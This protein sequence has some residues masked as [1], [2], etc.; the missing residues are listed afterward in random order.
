MKKRVVVTGVGAVTPVGNTAEDFW[1]SLV[2]GKSGLGPI[3]QINTDNFPV[4]ISAEVKNFDPTVYMNPKE[5]RR[6]DIFVHFAVA[7]SKM[8]VS[9]AKIETGQFDPYRFGVLIG[10]G[11]GGLRV[12]EKQ[13]QVLLEKGPSRISP[14]MIP[15]LICNIAAGIVAIEAG[16]KGP[17]SCAVTACASGTHSIGDA[18]KIIQRGD[19]DLMIS[20]GSES[21]VTELGLSGFCSMKALST[22]N[23]DPLRASRPF[24][25]ERDG[26]V[27]GE[28]A[29]ILILEELE[30]AIKRGAQIYAEICGYGMSC[31][32]YHIT[33]PDPSA[34]AAARCLQNAIKDASMKP[35]DIDYINAHGTST[36]LN[37]AT[38]TRAIKIA[39]GEDAAR[40]V[41]ISSTK[42]MTGH[43]LG[44]AGG[45]EAIASVLAI[46]N[47]LIPP[48][49]N[50]E[51][52]DPDC[53]L[54]YTPN[55]ACKTTVNTALSNS[56]G[57]GG[58]NASLVFKKYVA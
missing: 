34:N 9:D 21:C 33:A 13:H 43:L 29:G 44:A 4:K 16:A 23:D 56:L 57:F 53:D 17:N 40:K 47:D 8:A 54:D 27:M 2:A 31:D 32:A 22:R 24:D 41:K 7:A 50:Y 37:D 12:T 6:T 25:K 36:P 30:H 19:A 5:A 15:M 51:N 39:F 42:S 49:I 46:K 38:E 3:T 14:F 11:I 18:F 35:E 55:E 20:G 10:S 26:F 58:H 1:K 28:G 52:P 48:T 45:V